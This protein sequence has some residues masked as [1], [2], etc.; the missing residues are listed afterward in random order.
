[1]NKR[2]RE[3][4]KVKINKEIAF[5]FESNFWLKFLESYLKVERK[6]LNNDN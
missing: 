3:R 6:T 2:E 1:M 5:L 4:D